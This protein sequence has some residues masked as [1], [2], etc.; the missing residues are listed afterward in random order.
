PYN[1]PL[2]YALDSLAL[3]YSAKRQAE[4]AEPLYVR[5][6]EIFE[7]I[8][9]YSNAQ[10]L[11][12]LNNLAA[13]YKDKSDY[14][15]AETLY[16]KV[17]T[18]YEKTLPP[19]H[20][21]TAMVLNDL[22]ILYL[23][24]GNYKESEIFLQRGL[25]AS[26]KKGE[27]SIDMAR[28]VN[29]LASLYV[30]RGEYEK[31]EPMFK[32]ALEIYRKILGDS[33]AQISILLANLGQVYT[34]LGDYKKG[35][36]L[37]Q[38]SLD[39]AKKSLGENH[40]RVAKS[41]NQLAAV[42]ITKGD[43]RRGENLLKKSI[44]IYQKTLG[45]SHIESTNAINNLAA[46]YKTKGEYDKAEA[47]QN[48]NLQIN[49]KVFGDSS[50]QVAQSLHNMARLYI[51][52][53]EYKKAE[54]LYKKSLEMYEKVVGASHPDTASSLANLG[55]LYRLVERYDEAEIS[56]KKSLEIYE[57]V[58]GASH[59]QVS[60]ALNNLG[61]IYISKEEYLKAEPLLQRAV[62]IARNSVGSSHPLL[63]TGLRNMSLLSEYKGKIE[64][65]IEYQTETNKSRE[66]FL[67]R[68]L[69]AG[70]ERQKL[71]FLNLSEN[72]FHRTLSLHR[73]APKNK[74]A[75][76]ASLTV[77]LQRKG[78]ALDAM[79]QNIETLRTRAAEGDRELLDELSNKRSELSVATLKGIGKENVEGYK[80][81]LNKLEKDVEELEE[82]VGQRV[83]EFKLQAQPITLE[84]VQKAIPEDTVL[85]EFAAYKVL[86]TKTKENERSRYVVYTL[87]RNGMPKWVDLG[88]TETIDNAVY[89]LRTALRNRKSL[90]ATDI[91]PA[92]KRVDRLVM[93]PVRKLLAGSRKRLVIS[94][95]GALNVLP[96]AAL[97]DETGKYLIEK[98]KLSYLTSG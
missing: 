1:F 68:N 43:Y 40:P 80:E 32:Q 66:Q 67:V 28:A 65:A 74:Q 15:K 94:P 63:I 39:I 82:K 56:L 83:A 58:L 22:G 96:F 45:T 75:L 92:A 84:V 98:Y 57:N 24:K 34:E 70:S 49:K 8:L 72:D 51:A 21:Q 53:K 14:E 95:D 47:L 71:T 10:T 50:I 44:E 2:A 3:I 6:L 76:L 31:A 91:I 27:M 17:L 48:R 41:F 64:E 87:E 97:I 12:T 11:S 29:T 5:A 59:P 20:P 18:T 60:T 19:S 33:H 78:R 46:L 89:K 62:E 16:K 69:T 42:Y 85:I 7:K 30:Y 25:E 23:E 88:E 37:L 52:K 77:V 54:L 36:D 35:E 61:L 79:A 73:E 90:A 13:L 81:R 93:K 55:A 9:G 26:K 4:K 86:N 38:K